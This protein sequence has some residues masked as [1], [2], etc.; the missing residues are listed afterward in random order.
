MR[1]DRGQA[2]QAEE[3]GKAP[4]KSHEGAGDG[5]R[6]M[7]QASRKNSRGGGGG[8]DN[9]F[10][11]RHENNSRGGVWARSGA[12]STPPKK[13]TG[14]KAKTS[15]GGKTPQQAPISKK[16]QLKQYPAKNSRGKKLTREKT[17]GGSRRRR[18]FEA[19]RP[20]YL[21]RTSAP[22][23]RIRAAASE[24]AHGG[25]GWGGGG[26]TP[27]PQATPRAR[28]GAWRFPLPAHFGIPRLKLSGPGTTALETAVTDDGGNKSLRSPKPVDWLSRGSSAGV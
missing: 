8:C 1:Q 13:L 26:Q 6:S 22:D 27:L 9:E 23:H 4:E 18:D 19:P 5:H 17:H 12:L 3:I 2:D 16:T 14:V 21:T 28:L 10:L 7:R 24:Q 15:R 25:V 20:N 11:K